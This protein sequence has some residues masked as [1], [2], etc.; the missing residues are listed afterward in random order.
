VN[1]FISTYAY[2]KPRFV[3]IAKE[4]GLD[5]QPMP[6]TVEHDR[7]FYENRFAALEREYRTWARANA[8]KAHD[9]QREF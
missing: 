7:M 2:C 9:D 1:D 8:A 4:M 5:Y 3:Q 6:F